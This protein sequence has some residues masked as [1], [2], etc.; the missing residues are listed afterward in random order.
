[1]VL[2]DR[3]HWK[4]MVASWLLESMM[5]AVREFHTEGAVE[6]VVQLMAVTVIGVVLPINAE[7]TPLVDSVGLWQ[8]NPTCAMHADGSRLLLLNT[9]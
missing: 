7:Y 1:M 8:R 4:P 9:P 2:V 6:P 3:G 5:F